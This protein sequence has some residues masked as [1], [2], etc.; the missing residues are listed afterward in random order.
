[1]YIVMPFTYRG[2]LLIEPCVKL[3]TLS[4]VNLLQT[5][6]SLKAWCNVTPIYIKFYLR[7]EIGYVILFFIIVLN[8]DSFYPEEDKLLLLLFLCTIQIALSNVLQSLYLLK[9]Y[10]NHVNVW[11][12]SCLF[13]FLQAAC[14]ETSEE[15]ERA[16]LQ[17]LLSSTNGDNDEVEYLSNY[18]WRLLWKHYMNSG[19]IECWVDDI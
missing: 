10:I 4:K 11:T 15:A 14:D 19:C 13:C 18:V 16:F 6:L 2:F 17:L 5:V 8:C 3:V 7:S 12:I 9:Y 1:M